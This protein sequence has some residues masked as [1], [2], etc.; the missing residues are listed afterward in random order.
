MKAVYKDKKDSPGYGFLILSEELFPAPPW[1]ISLQRSSD[2]NFLASKGKWAGESIFI[3]LEGEAKDDGSLELSINPEI[4]DSLSPQDQYKITLKG[5]DGSDLTSR[6]K[7]NS[8]TFSRE[9]E[10]DNTAKNQD[11]KPDR[12]IPETSP[13]EK[14]ETSEVETKPEV[15]TTPNDNLQMPAPESPGGS[16]SWRWLVVLISVIVIGGLLAWVLMNFLPDKQTGTSPEVSTPQ[17]QGNKPSAQDMAKSA[18]ER[19]KE[20]FANSTPEP[21]AALNLAETLPKSDQSDQDAIY[22]LYYF[23]M[24]NNDLEAFLPYGNCLDPS[25]PQWGTIKKN[26]SDAMKAYEKAE[27]FDAE[28]ARKAQENLLDWLNKQAEAG[29][30]QAK[31]WLKEITK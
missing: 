27:Q 29:D 8:I 7:V 11:A 4:V 20:F 12:A 6:L 14:I 17:T 3:P 16:R 1:K 15:E 10:R 25:T 22:R 31:Q 28:A 30:T 23:A 9:E 24:T 21:H 18:A 5:S 26:A 13:Q 19:V 2:Q